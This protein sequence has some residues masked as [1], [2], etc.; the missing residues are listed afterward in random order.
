MITGIRVY[1]SREGR[2][3]PVELDRPANFA[4]ELL[5]HVDDTGAS[6]FSLPFRNL[7]L[8]GAIA[9][10]S[11]AVPAIR[12]VAQTDYYN[13]DR[14]R[15]VQIEDAYPTERYAFE[16]KLAPVRLERARGGVYS[17]EVDPEIAYGFLPRT[18][19]DV[20]VP[21][22]YADVGSEHRAGLAGLDLSALYNLNAETTTLPALGVRA[23]VLVPV[24][25][26]APDRAYGSFTGLAT[27]TFPALRIHANAQYTLGSAPGVDSSPS[28]GGTSVALDENAAELSRWLAGVV[29]DKTLPLHSVLFSAEAYA[30][31]PIISSQDVE[32]VVGTGVRYQLNTLLAVDAGVGRRLNGASR[33]WYVTF[34]TAYAFGVASLMPGGAR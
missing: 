14:G 12:A 18:Q 15:P 4:Q 11:L 26:L 25:N 5:V 23:D 30:R 31:Q 29:V 7:L 8:A 17:W 33:A 19:L 2:V 6:L 21:I 24:G 28:V 27:R 10:V 16:L 13:T 1:H 34:G 22:A 3:A 9:G 32:Y 20:G